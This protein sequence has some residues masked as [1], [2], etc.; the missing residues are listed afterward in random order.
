MS[1]LGRREV[2][3]GLLEESWCGE[4]ALSPCADP[5]AA[6]HPLGLAGAYCACASNPTASGEDE[7][8]EALFGT[9]SWI[10][11]TGGIAGS[12]LTPE[13]EGYMRTLTFT[14]PNQVEMFRDGVVEA[15]TTF[16]FVPKTAAGSA[17]R[18]AQLLYTQSV[19]GFDEQWV[20]ILEIENLV[21]SDPCCD[22]FVYE[23][24]REAG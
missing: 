22:G 17:V 8:P 14:P 4:V 1:R 15:T 6:T 3:H 2:G 21:L 18:S 13:S 19:V 7:L 10:R 16:V 9:W 5:Q 11:A 20:E 24:R 23:W 12:T